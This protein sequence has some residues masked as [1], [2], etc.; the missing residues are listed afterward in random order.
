M[1][2]SEAPTTA[3]R[4]G[5]DLVDHR[6]QVG[7]QRLGLVVGGGVPG[8]VA[9]ARGRRAPSPGSRVPPAPRRCPSRR[10]GSGRRRAAASPPARRRARRRRRR[11]LSPDSHGTRPFASGHDGRAVAES[12]TGRGVCH[13]DRGRWLGFRRARRAVVLGPAGARLSHPRGAA[14]SGQG[15]RC[16][17]HRRSCAVRPVPWGR[18]AGH[19]S[20]GT[21]RGI[22]LGSNVL[23]V[24]GGLGGPARVLAVEFGCS[25]TAVDL[26]PSYVEAARML[27]SRLGLQERVRH[28]VA[29]ALDLPFDAGAFDVVW[30]QNSGM[31]IADKDGSL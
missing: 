25:V 18:K 3:G 11:S 9:V 21:S 15:R 10:G 24:G 7:G 29:D 5:A 27:T 19:R 13:A 4:L 2:P 31:N 28:E 26:T 6:Q 17:D 20:I 14:C 23:D 1:P 22:A 12:A 16:L 8:R 30:T